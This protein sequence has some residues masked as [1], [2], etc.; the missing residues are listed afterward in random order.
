MLRR[1]PADSLRASALDALAADGA[2]HPAHAALALD[3]VTA[4]YTPDALAALDATLLLRSIRGARRVPLASFYTGY[5]KSVLAPD[6]LI[7]A[8]E[9]ALPPAGAPFVWRKVGTRQAQAISK[10]A[11]AGVGVVENGRCAR[12]GLGMASVAPT[13]ALL[14]ATRALIVQENMRYARRQLMWFRGEAGVRWI[15]TRGES[16]EAREQAV[17]GEINTRRSNARR[18]PGAVMHERVTATTSLEEAAGASMI[19]PA[20][21]CSCIARHLRSRPACPRS[22]R[23]WSRQR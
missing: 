16:D 14:P 20:S 9:I 21:N 22:S 3:R 2:M 7:E 6:E 4:R 18:L 5:R 15:E 23:P 8:V 12:L 17:A 1:D 19:V 10:V 11:L 13:V